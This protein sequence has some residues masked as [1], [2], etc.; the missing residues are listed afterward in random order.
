MCAC[1]H[2][3]VCACVYVCMRVCVCVYVCVGMCVSMDVH[4]RMY[5]YVT[6]L[7]V[8]TGE[9]CQSL[10]LSGIWGRRCMLYACMR[11]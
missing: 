7:G 4:T 11:V 5:D 3:C 9:S 1:E 6:S 10:V 8:R 2:V